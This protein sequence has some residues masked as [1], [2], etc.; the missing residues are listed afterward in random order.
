MKMEKVCTQCTL[1]CPI[2]KLLVRNNEN[3]IRDAVSKDSSQ[4]LFDFLNTDSE[5]TETINRQTFCP[6]QTKANNCVIMPLH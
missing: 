5:T 3:R 6:R 2:S 1:F 4:K